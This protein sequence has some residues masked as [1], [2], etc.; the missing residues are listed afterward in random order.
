M[1]TPKN[2]RRFVFVSSLSLSLSVVTGGISDVAANQ[3]YLAVSSLTEETTEVAEVNQDFPECFVDHQSDTSLATSTLCCNDANG[4][5]VISADECG[6]D[7]NVG[8]PPCDGPCEV[9]ENPDGTRTIRGCAN[10]DC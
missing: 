8:G 3:Q 2:V 10:P 9:I 5:G 1:M 4:D 6:C 7:D